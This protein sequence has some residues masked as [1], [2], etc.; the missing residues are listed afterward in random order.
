M[1]GSVNISLCLSSS[2]H[3]LVLRFTSNPWSLED[4]ELIYTLQ[5]GNSLALIKLVNYRYFTLVNL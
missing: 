1:F 2:I 5:I 3:G 4:I